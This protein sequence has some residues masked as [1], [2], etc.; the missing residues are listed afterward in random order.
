MSLHNI[1]I[2]L[3]GTLFLVLGVLAIMTKNKNHDLEKEL[4][5]VRNRLKS[6]NHIKKMFKEALDASE[7]EV[8]TLEQQVERLSQVNVGF[9]RFLEEMNNGVFYDEVNDSIVTM[10]NLHKIG[11][12]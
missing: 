11:D 1:V 2:L 3:V 6:A 9:S 7:E 5:T 8:R 12:L 4:A 10:S